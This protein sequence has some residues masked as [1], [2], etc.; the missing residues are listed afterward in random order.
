[1][2][3]IAALRCRWTAAALSSDLDIGDSM[4]VFHV[5]PALFGADGIIGGAERY[6]LELAR[7]MALEVPT[8]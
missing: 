4:R 5:V 2:I 6:A 3:K 7:H 8:T 1:M